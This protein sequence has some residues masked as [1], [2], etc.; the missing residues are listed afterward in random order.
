M[1]LTNNLFNGWTYVTKFV[2]SGFIMK[3]KLITKEL[4]LKVNVKSEI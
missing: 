4:Q 2:L 3:K 1:F